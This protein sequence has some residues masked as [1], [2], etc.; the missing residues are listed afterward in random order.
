MMRVPVLKPSWETATGCVCQV[1]D[2][3]VTS[4]V[5]R[6]SSSMKIVCTALFFLFGALAA[7]SAPVRAASIPAAS[8]SA[9]HFRNIGP[10]SGRIDAVTGVAGNSLAYYAGGL[11]GIFKTTDGGLT[12]KAIFAHEPVSSIG[13]L[14]TAPSD[15]KIVYAGT[16]EANLRNDVAFGDGV[17]RSTD[18][19]ARWQHVGLDATGSIAAIAVSPTD[20]NTAFVAAL[21]DQY[22]P[23]TERGIYRTTDGGKTWKKVLYVGERSGGSSVAI[24]PAN[25]KIV[26]AGIWEGWR[27][28]YHLNSGGR[29]DG[30]YESTDGGDTWTRLRGH[31]LPAG[32]MGRIAVAFAPSDPQRLYALIESKA[33]TL[34]RSDDGGATWKLVNASHGIDQRP[35]YFTSMAVDP[36]DRNHVYFMSVGMWQTKDGGGKVARVRNTKGGDYH[37]MWIDPHDSKRM[38]AGGDQGAEVSVDGG[39]TWLLAPI[40]I[41]QSYHVAVDD[42]VPYTVC[43]EDQDAGSACGPSNSL[44]NGGIGADAWFSAGGGESGWI[45]IDRTDSNVIYGDGY[46]GDVTRYDR[47]TR[48]ARAI[49]IW[50]EDDMGWPARKLKYRFQWTAPLALSPF[51]PDLLYMGGNRLFETADGG[52]T[53][54]AI[55]P[56][57]TRND[58]ARQGFSG[59]PVT[60]DNTSVEYYDTIFSIAESHRRRGEIWVGTDDGLAWLTLD[61]GAH[62]SDV[63]PTGAGFAPWGR[64]DYIDPSPFDAAAAYMVVDYHKS[65]DRSPHLYKTTNYGRDWTSISGNLPRTS[66]ARMIKEDPFRRGLLYVGTETGLWVSFDDGGAWQ[67]L[68]NN[69]PTVPIYDFTVQRHFDDLVVGTHGRALWILDD[70]SPLQHLDAQVLSQSAYLFPVREAYRYRIGDYTR[71]AN[72]WNGANPP[73]GADVNFYLKSAPAKK[74]KVTLQILDGTT[75]IRTIDVKKPH[76]GVNRVWWNLRYGAIHHVKGFVPWD[77]GG[78]RGPLA[79]PGIYTVRLDAAGATRTQSLRVLEDPR[80]HATEAELRSQLAF[81]LRIRSDE[82]RLTKTIDRLNAA[83][84]VARKHSQTALAGQIDAL[85]HRIYEPEVTQPEDAL[86]YP[87]HVYGRLSSLAGDAAS[88]DA[89][90]TASEMQVLGRLEREM[91][92]R[93]ARA[94]AI[95]RASPATAGGGSELP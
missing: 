93:I 24:D 49:N 55:S 8:Y 50:P 23:T 22:A 28:P 89:A 42:R 3:K 79:L 45:V 73:Y 39:K 30:L 51:R 75:V 91:R 60:H 94:D 40:A 68:Q 82:Q 32:P 87:I 69:L 84:A 20:A 44:S 77:G 53:W 63:T 61:G 83:L 62:W 92:A 58:K 9:L 64:V 15:G 67:P 1:S 46:T 6:Q 48:Q 78:F 88:A 72:Y 13:A 66:Y 74:Q 81:L 95:L 12:W 70:I 65:G 85:R 18:A 76:A 29:S 11:G 35:F 5:S 57:L 43:S 25:P 37:S 2:T 59:G 36:N 38:V 4:A 31:G 56:D 17:W 21:G 7:G 71:G 27:N 52:Q 19:G 26:F 14:A 33:G 86:R 10:T 47:R 80:S 90:P 16:G 34:W 54:K 41:A